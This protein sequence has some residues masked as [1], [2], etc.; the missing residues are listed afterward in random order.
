MHL[1]KVGIRTGGSV[2]RKRP[3]FRADGLV[4]CIRLVVTMPGGMDEAG[5]CSRGRVDRACC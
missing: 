2:G 3:L 5:T 4:A 1:R